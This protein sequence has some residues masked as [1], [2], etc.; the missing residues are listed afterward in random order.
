MILTNESGRII[1]SLTALIDK[2]HSCPASLCEQ[3][4]SIS[5]LHLVCYSTVDETLVF[6]AILSSHF[7]QKAIYRSIYYSR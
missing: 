7:Y 1:L 2:L 4:S 3:S 5:K 6:T